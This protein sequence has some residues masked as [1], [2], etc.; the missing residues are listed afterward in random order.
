VLSDCVAAAYAE[1]GNFEAAVR[2][3]E[4]SIHLLGE[5]GDKK[6]RETLTH[7]LASFKAKKPLREGEL[8]TTSWQV[9]FFRWP[10]A[11]A[12]HP[13]ADWESVISSKPAHVVK[14]NLIDFS[15]GAKSPHQDVPNDH[16]A[17]VA[18]TQIDWVGLRESR[19]RAG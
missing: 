16:F 19:K 7:A 1:A 12:Q 11:G 2:S 6:R 10:D 3:S 8:K 5:T 17:A 14:T 4:E 15:W 18:T 9:E 13:P